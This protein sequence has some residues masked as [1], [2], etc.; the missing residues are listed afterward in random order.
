MITAIVLAM[1]PVVIVVGIATRE[2][3][4]WRRQLLNIRAL[5]EASSPEVGNEF[6]I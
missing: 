4:L 2:L 3:R 1:L 5:P 6:A